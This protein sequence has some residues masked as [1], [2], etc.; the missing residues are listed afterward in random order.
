MNNSIHLGPDANINQMVRLLQAE[1]PLG[2]I[3]VDKPIVPGISFS[4]DPDA[5][6]SGRLKAADGAVLSFA[7][8]E[9]KNSGWLALHISMGGFDL[10][11]YGVIGFVCKTQAPNAIA[12]RACI[13]SGTEAGFV[14][15][16]FD[17]HLVGY[18][19]PSTHLDAMDVSIQKTLPAQAPWRDFVLFL[20]PD[21]PTDLT[22]LDLRFFIV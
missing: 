16:F 13:R 5:E 10:A 6:L 12:L 18:S 11:S 19:E 14:D 4:F 15:C 17:K 2:P 20:P 9:I 1:A 8:E 22:L 7:I 3:E 21:R